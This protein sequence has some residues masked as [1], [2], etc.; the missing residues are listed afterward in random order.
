MQMKSKTEKILMVLR[1]FAWL[2]MIGYAINAGSQLICLGV[3]FSHP[4][5]ARKI[6]GIAQD[7]LNLL[8]KDFQNYALL[9]SAVIL[10]SAL[11]VYLWHTVIQLLSKLNLKAPFTFEVTTNLEKIAY[12]LFAIWVVGY[13]CGKYAEWISQSLGEPLNLSTTGGEFLFIAG[14]VYIIS[15]IFRL[16]IEMQE[17]NQQTI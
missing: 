13:T 17:E 12:W 2:A 11:S 15:Q 3:S 8:Q 4:E 9:L 14:I 16:G 6:P 10:H 1:V 5:A 7:L